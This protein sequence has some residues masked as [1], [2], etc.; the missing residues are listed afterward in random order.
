[1][2][3]GVVGHAHVQRRAVGFGVDGDGLDAELAAGADH[4]HGDLAAVGDQDFLEHRAPGYGLR[5]YRRGS[6]GVFSAEPV[7]G[8]L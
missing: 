8:S 4:A 1:M 7:A 5:G 2:Q 6:D 3:I